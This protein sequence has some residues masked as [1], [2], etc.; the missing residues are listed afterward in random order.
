MGVSG[1]HARRDT[2][3]EPSHTRLPPGPCLGPPAGRGP[4]PPRTGPLPGPVP[5]CCPRGICPYPLPDGE[6]S[7]EMA[8]RGW[9][10]MLT[11]ARVAKGQNAAISP[12]DHRL[13]HVSHCPRA[14][15]RLGEGHKA[16]GRRQGQGANT[17]PPPTPVCPPLTRWP[18]WHTRD[19]G[20]TDLHAHRPC[21]HTQHT[22][23]RPA[24]H[25]AHAATWRQPGTRSAPHPRCPQTPSQQAPPQSFPGAHRKS[26]PSPGNGLTPQGR[27]QGGA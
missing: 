3:S 5:T 22:R 10:R 2:P 25:T 24:S 6:M 23:H 15:L 17:W 13:E 4:L 20:S 16:P 14:D 7:P 9:C 18:R 11:E 19:P 21:R 8:E 12:T 27:G 1:P 26:G